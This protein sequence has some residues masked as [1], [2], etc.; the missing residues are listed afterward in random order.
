V[1]KKKKEREREIY[2]HTGR[3]RERA[4]DRK[5]ERERRHC[6]GVPSASSQP[7]HTHSSAL[8]LA[9]SAGA[10]THACPGNRLR[11]KPSLSWVVCCSLSLSLALSG[12]A[13]DGTSKDKLSRKGEEVRVCVCVNVCGWVGVTESAAVTSCLSPPTWVKALPALS[14]FLFHCRFWFGFCIKSR[15]LLHLFL[16]PLPTTVS[17]PCTRQRT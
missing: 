14:F 11:Q 6:K 5:R 13:L 7:T 3:E 1:I 15:S 17:L 4:R 16:S 2:T 9:C 12:R 8:T 10:H